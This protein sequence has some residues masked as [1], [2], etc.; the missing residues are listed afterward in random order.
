MTKTN[1][2][3]H[4]TWLLSSSTFLPPA[5][6]PLPSNVATTPVSG[7]ESEDPLHIDLCD[8]VG[9]SYSPKPTACD[10]EVPSQHFALP[11]TQNSDE[12]LSVQNRKT[13]ARLQS[14]PKTSTK[15]KL[16]SQGPSGQVQTPRSQKSRAPSTSLRDQYNALYETGAYL[17]HR[18][19]VCVVVAYLR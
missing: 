17:C 14:G 16:L 4:L 5:P 2:G 18:Y 12:S 8:E 7:V 1:L 9:T 6:H 15:S 19:R 13:M 3:A 10:V 11:I